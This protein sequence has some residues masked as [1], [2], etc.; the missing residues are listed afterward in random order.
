MSSLQVDTAVGWSASAHRSNYDGLSEKEHKSFIEPHM[1]PPINLDIN[2]MDYAIW[3][4]HQQ[5]VYHQRQFKTV[6]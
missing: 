4:A 6:E 3:G 5:R 2:P 1:R